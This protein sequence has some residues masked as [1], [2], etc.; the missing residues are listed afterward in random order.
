M[1]REYTKRFALCMTGLFCYSFG[2]VFSVKA[3]EVGTNAWNTLA[4][5]ISETA[6]V[7]FGTATMLISCVMSL[8]AVVLVMLSISVLGLTCCRPLTAFSL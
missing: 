2:N 6:A 1:I 7:S 5:G 8:M 4:M 3:G